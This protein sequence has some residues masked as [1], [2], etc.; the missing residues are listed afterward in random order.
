M[1]FEAMRRRS[2]AFL[3]VILISS[4][5]KESSSRMLTTSSTCEMEASF[6]KMS[7]ETARTVTGI[8]AR[9]RCLAGFA[10]KKE[11]VAVE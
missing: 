7:R 3:I 10:E 5:S 9:L 1:K 8:S 11:V 4:V 6:W 2:S